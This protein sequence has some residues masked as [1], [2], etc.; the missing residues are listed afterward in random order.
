MK[1]RYVGECF[2][3]N[4]RIER[5]DT[6]DKYRDTWAHVECAREA[7]ETQT[8]ASEIIG[9]VLVTD[10]DYANY[11]GYVEAMAEE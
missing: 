1:A 8:E 3:C 10:L 9:P 5:G 2:W 11:A 7:K 6:I 4:Q